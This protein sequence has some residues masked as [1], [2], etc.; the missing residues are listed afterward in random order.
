MGDGAENTEALS[1]VLHKIAAARKAP[2][3]P[4]L[5]KLPAAPSL[6]KPEISSKKKR[7]HEL[8]GLFQQ[9]KDPD[10]KVQHFEQIVQS[11]EPFIQSRL[12]DFKGAEVSKQSNRFQLVKAIRKAAETY[13]P[14]KGAQFQSW[15]GT[16]FQH[17]S[18]H[19]IQ[20]QNVAR[21]SEGVQAK[22]TAYKTGLQAFIDKHEREPATHELAHHLG[23]TPK[24]VISVRKSLGKS[25]EE[26]DGGV[27]T[28]G[29][30]HHSNN[31]DEYF[32]HLVYHDLKPHEQ[33]VHELMYPKD[34]TR[35]VTRTADIA[36]KL[37]WPEPK[38]SKAK[39]EI[40]RRIGQFKS[41]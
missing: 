38:V 18:R 7:E 27:G 13:N 31:P 24:D 10:K 35:A 33:V 4:A 28:E 41:E 36:K 5:S 25:Y 37:K 21:V 11:L 8:V 19:V 1:W 34:G 30:E 20:N 16:H 22:M 15:V 14:S 39:T 40:L 26:S 9:E 17:L 29:V 2:A 6:Q 32:A 23:W 3:A 12:N